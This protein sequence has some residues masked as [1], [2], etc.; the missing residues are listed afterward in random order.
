MK[1]RL[2]YLP[3][4]DGKRSNYTLGICVESY[5][6]AFHQQSGSSSMRLIERNET[7]PLRQRAHLCQKTLVS[8]IIINNYFNLRTIQLPSK[9]SSFYQTSKFSSNLL[10]RILHSIANAAALAT[11]QRRGLVKRKEKLILLV[12]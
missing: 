7:E 5:L 4:N 1:I 10:P 11:P 2:A 9:L 3:R 6:A 8:I 12:K